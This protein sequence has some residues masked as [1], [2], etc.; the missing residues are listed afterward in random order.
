V[1]GV[2]RSTR[3]S[4][5]L[6]EEIS[7]AL[8]GLSDPRLA[9]VLISRVEMTD[10]LQ[11]AR[12][13]VRREGGGDEQ[14]V[15]ATLKALGSAVGRLRRAIRQHRVGQRPR[16]RRHVREH[17]VADGRLVG[18]AGDAERR[19]LRMIE[20]AHLGDGHAQP[21]LRALLQRP[22]D[23]PLVLER[24]RADDLEAEPHHA[25]EHRHPFSAMRHRI[26]RPGPVRSVD[27]V[28]S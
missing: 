12:V 16:H 27:D 8:R 24:S 3:V 5:R 11:T 6:T 18:H 26:A 10:D 7:A 4:A 19:V 28:G 20:H 14:E 2:K 1:S 21:G 25:D 23:A 17:A 13:Y 15:K 9:G 22:H